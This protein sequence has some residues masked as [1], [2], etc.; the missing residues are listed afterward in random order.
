VAED[1]VALEEEEALVQVREVMLQEDRL[2]RMPR[3]HKA[4][5]ER[6]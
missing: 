5:M 4:A 3:L 6:L 2:A 1:Q